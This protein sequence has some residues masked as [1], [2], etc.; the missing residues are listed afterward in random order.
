MGMCG[1][2]SW[3]VLQVD[4]GNSRTDVSPPLSPPSPEVLHTALAPAALW[5]SPKSAANFIAQLRSSFPADSASG[6]PLTLSPGETV[7]VQVPTSVQASAI[8]WEFATAYGDIGFGVNF[9]WREGEASNPH[10]KHSERLL[11][12]TVRN[13]SEDLVLGSHQ[14]QEQGTYTLDFVN[15]HS[16]LPKTIYYKVFYQATMQIN[17]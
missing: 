3:V 14:Y 17:K 2:C 9:Q 12:V 11:P 7:A 5:C 15:S 16:T 4:T 10:S 13:C 1:M 6:G 8:F